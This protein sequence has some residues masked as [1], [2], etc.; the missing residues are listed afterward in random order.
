MG[1]GGGALPQASRRRHGRKGRGVKIEG[2]VLLERLTTVGVGGGARAGVSPPSR[3]GTHAALGVGGASD[4][5]R[6]PGCAGVGGGARPAGTPGG[7][8]LEL[9]RCRRRRRGA[10]RAAR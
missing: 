10:G 5:G 7:T 6:A 9:A 2:G 1:R 4:A 3:G 8:R